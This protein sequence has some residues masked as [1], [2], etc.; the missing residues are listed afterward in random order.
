MFP[1]LDLVNQSGDF[2][3]EQFLPFMSLKTQQGESSQMC[4]FGG[5][6]G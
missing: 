2:M 6:E 1:S 3:K 5:T 4:E